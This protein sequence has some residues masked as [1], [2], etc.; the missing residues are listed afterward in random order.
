MLMSLLFKADFIVYYIL[1]SLLGILGYL[2]S[3][4]E[5][6]VSAFVL[7]FVSTV[8]VL[9]HFAT[10]SLIYLSIFLWP[11]FFVS[12]SLSRLSLRSVIKAD[13]SLYSLKAFSLSFISAFLCCSGETLVV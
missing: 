4:I 5:T 3:C 1:L 7:L 8:V 11:S 13:L 9:K 10:I 2:F 12:S 6:L